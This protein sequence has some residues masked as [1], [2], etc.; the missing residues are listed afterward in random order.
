MAFAFFWI[1]VRFALPR[2]RFSIVNGNV[3]ASET[4][5]KKAGRQAGRQLVIQKSKLLQIA[6][7]KGR[8]L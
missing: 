7:G 5:S 1:K 2:F 8:S 3:P 4:V 6:D